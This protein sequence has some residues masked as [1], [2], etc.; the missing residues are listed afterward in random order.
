MDKQLQVEV[1]KIT[2][3]A[4]DEVGPI[5]KQVDVVE[6]KMATWAEDTIQYAKTHPNVMNEPDMEKKLRIAEE[7]LKDAGKKREEVI[8]EREERLNQVM[9]EKIVEAMRAGRIRKVSPQDLARY[10]EKRG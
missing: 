6:S 5:T 2:K 7:T 4:M 3:Q 10:Y 1:N 9:N 8:H